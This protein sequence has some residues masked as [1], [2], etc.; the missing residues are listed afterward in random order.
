[1]TMMLDDIV[2]RCDAIEECYEF[3]LGYAA[4]GFPDDRASP[5]GGRLRELLTGLVEASSGLGAAYGAIIREMRIEPPEPYEAF[6]AVLER[7]TANALAAVQLVLAQPAISS[8]LIDNLNGS[9]HLRTFLTDIFLIDE[10]VKLRQ[11]YL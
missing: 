1:M 11:N 3:M 5:S 10:V 4:Q 8:Q 7:D 9:I 2:R 6:L